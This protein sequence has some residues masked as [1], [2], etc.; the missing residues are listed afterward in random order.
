MIS[1]MAMVNLP[2]WTAIAWTP[3]NESFPCMQNEH[4]VEMYISSALLFTWQCQATLHSRWHLY[5][6]E[7]YSTELE[8]IGLQ[9]NEKKNSDSR[10]FFGSVLPERSLSLPLSIPFPTPFS[11]PEKLWWWTVKTSTYYSHCLCLY[12]LVCLCLCFFHC[13]CTCLWG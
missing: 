2:E 1:T 10:S 5:I 12:L 4:W 13:H 3:L 8:K 7:F 11:V 9:N 6:A